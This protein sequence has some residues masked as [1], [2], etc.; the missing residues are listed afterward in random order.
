[1]TPE[2]YSGRLSIRSLS[3]NFRT[4]DGTLRVLD[5]IDLAVGAGEIVGIVGETG[6]GKSVLAKSVLRLLPSETARYPQGAILWNGEDLLS[7][8]RRRLRQVRGTEI[9]MIFQD[10]MTFLDPLYTAGSYL[11]E[12]IGHRDQVRGRCSSKAERKAESVALL[13]SLRLDDPGR[14]FDSYPH[15]LSGGMRQRVL[16]AAAIAGGPKL[17]IADEPTTALDVTVQAQILHILLDLVRQQDVSLMLVS[18]DL[19]VIASICQRI[20]VMY[21]GT[22]VEEGPKQ[23][24]L[25]RPA[26]P[27]T[28]GLIA[29]VPR[30]G[31]PSKPLKGIAG[32]MPNLLNPPGGCRFSPRCERATALC[33]SERPRLKPHGEGGREVAC[34][35]P[36][37]VDA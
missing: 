9:G 8:P 32:Q 15:Q 7:V 13:G 14:V 1:M 31:Y 36:V 28:V 21:A 2:R 33:Q 5:E 34:H 6:C 17:L 35:Y 12:A 37:T 30:L 10:P 19:G 29:A 26:H 22:V 24:L 11:V 4:Y 27:Y 20:V 16:I 18:H 23:Q 25:S 3:L